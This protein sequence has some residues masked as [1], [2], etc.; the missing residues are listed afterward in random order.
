[1]LLRAAAQLSRALPPV[2]GRGR[3]ALALHR[4][5]A[6]SPDVLLAPM[7]HGFSMEV[8]AGSAQTWRAAFTG[9]YDDEEIDLLLDHLTPDSLVVDVGASLGFYTVPLA[10]AARE[11]GG[12]VVA[13]EPVGANCAV[14]RRNLELNGVADTVT[15]VQSALGSEQT[16]VV[17]HVESGGMGNAAIV[18]GL[19]PA[20][21]AMH[22]RAGR[23]GAT[24]RAE[25]RPLDDVALGDEHGRRR[26]SVV[27]IDAEGFEMEVLAG[28]ESFVDR[29]RPVIFGEFHPDW[30]ITRGVD[31]MAPAQWAGTHGYDCRELV[32]ARR[33]VMS[34]R[35]SLS[36]RPLRAGMRRSG[37]SLLLAPVGPGRHGAERPA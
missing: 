17:L 36:L 21:V 32:Y 33:H 10:Q 11:R 18:D 35:R 2:R 3:L 24:E 12:H 15:V 28:A 13:F 19:L 8:P 31:P 30:L 25:V 5:L 6:P 29:H 4:H 34:E 27:K 23:T 7:R 22:D 16:H 37:T 9:S 14:L 1:M 20:E 26:C